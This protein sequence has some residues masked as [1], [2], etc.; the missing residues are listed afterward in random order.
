MSGERRYDE[1]EVREI[2]ELAAQARETKQ[3]ALNSGE[4][5][6]LA[7]LQDIGLEVGLTRDEIAEAATA[8]EVRPKSIPSRR[9]LGL[10]LSVGRSIDLPRAPTDREWELLV[11]ELRD[12]FHARGRVRSEGGLRQ[13]TNG[14]LHAYIEPTP[15]GHR[16]KLGTLKGNA[17]AMGRMGSFGV[18]MGLVML[19]IFVLTGQL[20]AEGLFVPMFLAGMGGA[21]LASAA[22]SLPRWAREREAQME[23][24]AERARALIGP[25]EAEPESAG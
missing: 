9:M 20:A 6:T 10:P 23:Y 22:L 13:W 11:S 15:E 24:I 21:A 16:L 12:T 7:E 25:G 8:L 18:T 1:D 19:V 3:R 14:N 5:L 2:F 17:L 4:G